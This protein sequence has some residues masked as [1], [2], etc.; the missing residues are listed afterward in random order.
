[1]S[2]EHFSVDGS[3]LRAWASH[4][5]M[6]ARD[7]SDEPPGPDQGATLRSTSRGKKRRTRRTFRAPTP[8]RCWRPRRPAWPT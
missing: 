5:N 4:K 7:G 6:A 2:D 8:W 1:M 3:L